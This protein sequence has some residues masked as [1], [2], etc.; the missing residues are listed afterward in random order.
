MPRTVW[1][2]LLETPLLELDGLRKNLLERLE[3]HSLGR[4]VFLSFPVGID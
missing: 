4:V 2:R 3:P 1:S